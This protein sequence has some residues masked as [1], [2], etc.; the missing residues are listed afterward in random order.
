MR[1]GDEEGGTN[2]RP[3]SSEAAV[4]LSEGLGRDDT[5]APPYLVVLPAP[6]NVAGASAPRNGSRSGRKVL[7]P[8]RLRRKQIKS[9][10]LNPTRHSHLINLAFGM[11]HRSS[12]TSHHQVIL[13]FA[14]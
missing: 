5:Q 2:R 10:K 6:D 9:E 14:L 12:S 1:R 7:P 11:E 8:R 13:H 4:P 3:T